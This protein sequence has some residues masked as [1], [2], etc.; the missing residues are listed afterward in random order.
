MNS[1]LATNELIPIG[2]DI[3]TATGAPDNLGAI[4]V[5]AINA[6]ISLAGIAVL[7][8]L[9]WGGYNWMTSG[10]DP[11]KVSAARAR[12]THALIGLAIIA[13]IWAIYSIVD[14][15]FGLNILQ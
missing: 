8:Y 11:Q 14:K 7:F 15:F 10:G 2:G 13:S 9:I 3:K 12:I 6:L 1:L 5:P 4:I